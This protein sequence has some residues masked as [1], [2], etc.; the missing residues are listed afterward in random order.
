MKK[1]YFLLLTAILAAGLGFSAAAAPLTVKWNNPGSVSIRTGSLTG[2][3]VE[4]SD[5]ATEYVFDDFKSASYIYVFATD[6]YCLMGGT[7]N[8]AS[9]P[10]L[11][12]SSWGTPN[13]SWFVP[14]AA[15]TA[16]GD[17]LTI[18]VETAKVVRE[19]TFTINLTGD[20]AQVTA[21]FSGKSP[22]TLDLKEGTNTVYFNPEL[23]T[24]LTIGKAGAEMPTVSVDGVELKLQYTWSTSYDISPINAGCTIDI[25]APEVEKYTLTLDMPEGCYNTIC[26][27]STS[28]FIQD[29]VVDNKLTLDAN[30]DI[31]FNFNTTD[32][33][34]TKITLGTEDLTSSL[35]PDNGS[36]RFKVT[37][38]AT[39]KVEAKEREYANVT[40]R[41]VVE[42][43]QGVSIK[44]A[45]LMGDE[46]VT[47]DLADYAT[48]STTSSQSLTYGFKMGTVYNISLP[49]SEKYGKIFIS[50]K[51]GYYIQTA[52][53]QDETQKVTIAA[54][55]DTSTPIYIIAQEYKFDAKIIVN[56]F[57]TGTCSL[58]PAAD[59]PLNGPAWGNPEFS[60]ELKEGT[61]EI[62]ICQGAFLKDGAMPFDA[63]IAGYE[64]G[65]QLFV[66][67]TA[68]AFKVTDDGD[69]V[70][71]SYQ[72]ILATTGTPVLTFNTTHKTIEPIALTIE[73]D[74][75]A[76]LTGA[77]VTLPAT[78]PAAVW[79]GQT[80]TLTPSI[81][82]CTATLGTTELT[83]ADGK[84]TFT[85]PSAD[86]TLTIAAPAAEYKS[87]APADGSS[88]KS[89]SAFT[90]AISFGEA[91]MESG[92]QPSFDESLLEKV[93]IT[94]GTKT[95][96]GV[97]AGEAEP[98]YNSSWELEGMTFPFTLTEAAAEAGEWTL[99][100]PEGLI[101]TGSWNDET[102]S[103]NHDGVAYQA[104]TVKYSIDPNATTEFDTYT[105]TPA[106]G[107]A[108]SKI[109]ALWIAFPEISATGMNDVDFKEEAT[110]TINGQPANCYIQVDWNAPKDRTF[111]LMPEE[112]IEEAGEYTF[113]LPA[114][115]FSR[116]GASSPAM[117]A[118][119]RIS[120]EYPLYPIN[121]APDSKVSK[122]ASFVITFI[123]A[124]DA[125]YNEDIAI[126]IT[127]DGYKATAGQ[128]RITPGTN[129]ATIE[130]AGSPAAD[131]E[132]TLNI[133]EGA[134][135][136]DGY[137]ASE[138]VTAKYTYAANYRLTPAPGSTITDIKEFTIE[139]PEAEKVEFVGESYG[140]TAFQGQTYASPGYNV[141]EVA[142]ATCPTFR[143]T[144]PETAAK[145]S[146]GAI[147]LNIDEEIFIVDGEPNGLIR[148]NYTLEQE[149]TADYDLDPYNGVIILGEYGIT[150]A[151]LFEE[152]ST[153]RTNGVVADKTTIEFNGKKLTTSDYQ[154]MI[155]GNMIM[156]GIW[157]TSVLE[158]GTLT[159]SIEAGAY[160]LNG[161]ESPAISGSWKLVENKTFS[162]SL[163]FDPAQKQPRFNEIII[164]FPEA[165]SGEVY[166]AGGAFLRDSRYSYS[167]TATISLI[168]VEPVS[169][170]A[171]EGVA[172]KLTFDPE[173]T[174]DG[175]Y[176][177][178]VNEGT[179]TLDG[180]FSSPAIEENLTLDYLTGVE[181]VTAGFEPGAIYN[182]QGIRLDLEW[183]Q[184][185]PGV[186][187]R[188]GKKLLKK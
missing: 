125:E 121:P 28:K 177:L 183:N 171:G 25:K 139:F 97:T 32:F 144:L 111:Q 101:Y 117:T 30:T 159:L 55:S 87:I 22:L 93:T 150:F 76:I 188:D 89:L 185:A 42:N 67:A 122:L 162:Y 134:F 38:S 16:M 148:A 61:N 29:E 107:S 164:T 118:A 7:T 11:T 66:G 57:G 154:S 105:I 102:S 173:P 143:F 33:T 46:G 68:Q 145:P 83:F 6:G 12:V 163:G 49:V 39:L 94:N 180:A 165:T 21:S 135:T 92:L 176:I 95:I 78:K 112:P 45:Y 142:G 178:K 69:Q 160:L 131:G 124:V 166:Q 130:F 52:Q 182:L 74:D 62:E 82:N 170:A 51:P 175:Q 91:D 54:S 65:D 77:P 129:Y 44:A 79:P 115:L 20:P 84:F 123:G 1:L 85:A 2:P 104:L 174:T 50:A 106:S 132:Y 35:N 151:V 71:G 17:N 88:L 48:T 103:I 37:E 18:T 116:S 186:Y 99:S 47:Y 98:I 152:G 36:L 172:F 10:T 155:E 187:I 58:T 59:T 60:V 110:I 156:F 126:T 53:Q 43:P 23:D 14:A 128:V 149:F 70:P 147:I 109:E 4:L 5:D 72:P 108:I 137:T 119:Y 26:N 161:E 80:Y 73:G 114:G 56:K 24:K 96:T 167:Q 81:A 75:D 169:R 153:V 100:I 140:I 13:I 179:F 9:K 40:F 63:R 86:A 19:D 158:E 181:S 15:F 138:S 64:D 141:S 113:E 136:L 168:E 184:L 34:F 41:L 8:Y 133:P 27:W 157:D 3:L 31:S 146:N 90:L 120:P 127:G